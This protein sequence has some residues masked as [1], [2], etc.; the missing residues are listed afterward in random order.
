MEKDIKKIVEDIVEK[1]KADPKLLE[2]LKENPV[3]ALEEATGIDLPDEMIQPVVAGLK[4]KLEMG[5]IG[6]M[7]G[8][9]EG[10]FGK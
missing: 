4:A 3:K 8:K 2:S 7:I 1:V 6:D 10:L 5:E 9:L